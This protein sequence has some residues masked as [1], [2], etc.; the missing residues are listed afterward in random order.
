MKNGW[1]TNP[2]LREISIIGEIAHDGQKLL[3]VVFAEDPV[4]PLS[5]GQAER[6]AQ[7]LSSIRRRP[8][9]L[10]AW[11]QVLTCGHE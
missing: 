7:I 1:L 10:D 11:D 8:E 2:D 9:N 5:V 3:V 6:V 4:P